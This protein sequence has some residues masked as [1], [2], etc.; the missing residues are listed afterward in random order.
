MSKTVKFNHEILNAEHG[1]NVSDNPLDTMFIN[2]L[3][4]MLT[5]DWS[6]FHERCSDHSE[7]YQ[8]ATRNPNI[9]YIEPLMFEPESN[10]MIIPNRALNS[11]EENAMLEIAIAIDENL[12]GCYFEGDNEYVGAM[13]ALVDAGAG[14]EAT[15]MSFIN[16]DIVFIDED[17]Y[18]EL[19]DYEKESLFWANDGEP[20]TID[21]VAV[22]SY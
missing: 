6:E 13:Q 9:V 2:D 18:N 17:E 1:W 8:D 21:G 15:V 4:E 7:Y 20:F 12:L 5:G 19:D 11:D 14:A 16:G 10:T 22:I 3:G